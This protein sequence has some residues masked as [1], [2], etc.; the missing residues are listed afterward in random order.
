[1]E[2]RAFALITGAFVLGLLACL[3]AWAQWLAKEPLARTQY[4]V[5][6]AIAVAGLN[7][8][9]QVRYRGMGVGRVNTI[10]LDPMDKRRILI[11]IEVDDAIPVTRGTYAQLGMEGITGIAYV[12][13]LDDGKDQ[14]PAPAAAD[15]IA[16]LTLRPSF[17]DTISEGAEGTV[18]EARELIAA[19]HALLNEDNRKRIGSTLASLEKVAVNLEATSQRL[20]GVID[21]TDARLGAWLG[22][23]NR[24]LARESLERMN[25]AVASLPEL[26]KEARQLAQDARGLV[27]QIGKLS[28]EAQAGAGAV[29]EDTLPRV[30]ALADTVE[31]GAQRV[32]RLASELDRQ[33]ESLLWG[34]KPSRPG[35]GEPGFAP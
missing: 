7:P 25:E 12:H 26:T 8:E 17:M 21:R 14:Q 28:A 10:G 34:R 15:G 18:R 29:R 5:V 11:G 24:K 20:P 2:S 16:E 4:R 32:G 22:E 35:P 13:L 31:R 6:S 33:P 1:M 19:L 27:A 30:N 23:D 3:V 9:A